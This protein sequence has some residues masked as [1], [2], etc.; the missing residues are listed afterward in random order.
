VDIA[1]A[2]AAPYVADS[3]E[4]VDGSATR[5]RFS[6]AAAVI[7]HAFSKYGSRVPQQHIGRHSLS[8]VI[9]SP[10]ASMV[11]ALGLA[12]LADVRPRGVVQRRSVS[13]R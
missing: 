4:T 10:A 7:G 13:D 2:C 12:L 1:D 6:P 9:A 5:E 3:V 8:D 11:A